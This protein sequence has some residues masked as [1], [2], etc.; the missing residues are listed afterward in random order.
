[1]KP[2]PVFY[3]QLDYASVP[4]PSPVDGHGNVADN[5]CG[6]CALSMVAENLLGV[7]FPPGAAARFTMESGGR[8]EFGTNLYILSRAFGQRFGVRVIETEDAE[9][10]L[11]FL[12][13]GRGMVVANV[14][15]NRPDHIGV[16][17]DTGHY[18]VLIGA[19]GREARVLDPMY[20]PG[21]YDAPGRAGKVRMEGNVACADMS[22]IAADCFERPFFLFERIAPNQKSG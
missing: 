7:S 22:V 8:A 6:V 12:N 11:A 20:R 13:E 10:A 3:C 1:M 17:S 16:F 5:G 19:R 9:Q 15:G 4:L 14:R 2:E 18:I 21:R